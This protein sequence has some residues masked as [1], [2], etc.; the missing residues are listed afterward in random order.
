MI[1]IN[2]ERLKKYRAN[3]VRIKRDTLL[4]ECD[5]KM[6]VDATSDKAAWARYRQALRE[7]P[8]QKGFPE[9]IAWPEKPE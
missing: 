7:I 5:G 9:K 8:E 6:A 4:S 2:A 3:E 1:R